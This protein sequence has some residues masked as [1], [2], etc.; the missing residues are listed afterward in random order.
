MTALVASFG[1]IPMAL[2]T[3]TDAE[4]QRPLA[5]EVLGGIISLPF[6]TLVFLPNLYRMFLSKEA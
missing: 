3:G 1:F 4:V 5:T 6:L 2:A